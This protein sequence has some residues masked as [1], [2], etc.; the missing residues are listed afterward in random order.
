MT[1][2]DAEP[3]QAPPLPG[4]AVGVIDASSPHAGSLF[5]QG[6]A[7]GRRFDDVHGAG[8]RLVT[9]DHDLAPLDPAASSWFASIGGRAVTV[10]DDDRVYRRWFAGHDVTAALQRPDF[11]LHGTRAAGTA[12]PPCWITCVPG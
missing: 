2:V 3:A 8:W 12:R 5:V 10:P 1:R 9:I 7:G 6:T 4:I 11:Y